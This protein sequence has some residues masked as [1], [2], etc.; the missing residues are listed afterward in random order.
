MANDKK[1]ISWMFLALMGFAILAIISMCID[2]KTPTTS[3]KGFSTAKKQQ[4]FY[5]L[6][7]LQ[8]K[9]SIWDPEYQEKNQKA[10]ELIANQ[11]GISM[12]KLNDI[13]HEGAVNH[14]PMP[15]PP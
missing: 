15:P 8:D 7:A 9:I 11:Y 6:V 4:I 13:I 5:E 3:P 1:K 12:D 10:K 2:N 14:W